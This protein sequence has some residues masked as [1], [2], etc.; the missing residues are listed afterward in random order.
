[1]S[2]YLQKLQFSEEKK[3]LLSFSSE[4]GN[5]DS[6]YPLNYRVGGGN[7]RVWIAENV[8]GSYKATV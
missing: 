1:M 8:I 7:D 6:K 2:F 4:S 3:K 5:D